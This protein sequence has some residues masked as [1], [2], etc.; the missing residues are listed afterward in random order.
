MDDFDVG[1]QIGN[2]GQFGLVYHC[3]RKSDR[4]KLAV[5]T[6]NKARFYR[7][8]Q[9][10]Q[11]RFQLLSSMQGEINILQVIKDRHPS[12]I[13]VESVY[14]DRHF[15]YIVMQECKGGDLMDRLQEKI[16]QQ[17][18][19]SEPDAAKIIHSICSAI[20]VSIYIYFLVVFLSV[21]LTLFLFCFFLFCVSIC[22]HFMNLSIAI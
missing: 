2:A 6:I 9:N 19:Y 21:F 20:Y 10:S 5:K 7:L 12:I 16:K 3:R 1:R 22:I 17:K 8:G 4:K 11:E 13:N 14:E 15:L 18:L